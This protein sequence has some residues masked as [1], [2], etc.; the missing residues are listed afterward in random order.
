MK[1]NQMRIITRAGV[2]LVA[3]AMSLGLLGIT[4]TAADAD[5]GWA[6]PKIAAFK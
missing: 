4:A 6:R 5:S 3:T 2:A 1:V